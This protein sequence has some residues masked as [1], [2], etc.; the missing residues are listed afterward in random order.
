MS[1]SGK[2]AGIGQQTPADG[3]SDFNAISFMIE[4][5]LSKCRTSIPVVVMGIQSSDTLQAVGDLKIDVMPLVNQLD[6]A[7]TAVPHG[8]IF[9]VSFSRLQGG[10]NAIVCDPQVGDK[11]LMVMSDRDISAVKAT[12][13]QANPGSYRRFDLAD[14][15]YVGCMFNGVPE[16]YVQFT[17]D[18]IK[19]VQK[20]GNIVLINPDGITA[21]T[22][23]FTVT[24]NFNVLQN[25]SFGNGITGQFSTLTGQAIT[26][27]NGVITN[28]ASAPGGAPSLPSCFNLLNLD[29]FINL[30]LQIGSTEIEVDL[31]ALTDQV[32]ADISL[33]ESTITS[34]LAFLGPLAALLTTPGA[35]FTDII[36]WI[37]GVIGLLTMMY[38][39]YLTMTAQLPALA[40]Q[41]TALTA[42]INAQ[43]ALKGFSITIPTIS[44][45]CEL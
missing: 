32:F 31:Q 3:A 40:I 22:P 19:V 8:T 27:Q 34:Q 30:T 26:F 12:K 33:L 15:C 36:N 29:Y 9:G 41:I 18:T 6:G 4:Q 10:A 37:N 42:A 23:V 24:G 16:Q 5:K 43:A 11:G 39:P 1:D 20:N 38:A 25:A 44:V 17:G 2:T 13:A 45:I 35:N 14:G 28:M 7:G 21:T